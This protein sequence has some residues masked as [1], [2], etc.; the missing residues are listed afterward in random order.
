MQQRRR[1]RPLRYRTMLRTASWL[2]LLALWAP[3]GAQDD[4][5]DR[6]VRTDGSAVQGRIV[7]P[8]ADDEI[9]VAQG[10]KRVRVPRSAIVRI[11]SVAMRLRAF[12]QRRTA[13]KDSPK[14]QEFLIDEAQRDGFPELAR[15]QALWVV[16]H[17]DDNERAHTFL[18]HEKGSR[19]WLWQH[20][21]RRMLLPALEES[22]QKHPLRLVGE[23]FALRCDAALRTNV[24][25][26][27]DL[28][29]LG[30]AWIDRFGQELDLHEVLKPIEVVAHRN[31]SEFPKWGFRPIPYYV[32]A[33]YGDVARTFYAGSA[34][35]RPERLFF[36]GT[37]ALLYR[38]LIG[39][40]A[41]QDERDRVCAWL[42]IGF[43][44][45]MEHSMHGPAGFAALGELDSKDLQALQ[46][47][48]RN[49]RITHLL[50]LPM[51]GSFY[52]A[53]T[54]ETATNWAAATMFVAWLS[55]P[56][57]PA[58]TREPF[59]R[60][61]R[62]ALRDRKGDSSTAFDRTMGKRVE[63]Y[64]EPWRAWLAKTAGY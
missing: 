54:T 7:D 11:D 21:G 44:M 3:L 56:D 61:V 34:P 64:E 46:A 6:I 55:D 47:L 31:P 42:E 48:G 57:N 40:L 29:H 50:H 59:L 51:Y 53:D 32:P 37:H 20:D 58:K 9:T 33:P 23:R 27:F 1:I 38:T 45:L 62:A 5:R 28:E 10:G 60:Y 18:G 8:F 4:Q 52:L 26:L 14:A 19:G 13:L 24:A 12:L 15:L 17:D 36:V 49:H 63:D 35:I 25:A 41:R 30:V 16:L 39:E 43:A 22:L 2:A